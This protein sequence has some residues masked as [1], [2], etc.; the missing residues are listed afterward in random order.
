MRSDV[1]VKCF[2]YAGIEAIKKALQAAED[3]STEEVHISVRL[4]APPLY[5]MTTTST[6]KTGAIE[7]MEKAV[8]R[9]GEVITAEGGELSVKMKVGL[10]LVSDYPML[11]TFSP[12]S[13]PR[14]RMPSLRRSWS[15][16]SRQTWTWPEMTTLRRMSRCIVGRPALRIDI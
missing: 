9:I 4:V 6:D 11:T 15:S 1:E 8:E 16:S 7:I 5:V 14:L 2:A 3:C 10:A 12:V 13:S